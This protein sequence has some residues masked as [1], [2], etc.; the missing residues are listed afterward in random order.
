MNLFTQK[1]YE[2]KENLCDDL[3]FVMRR[4]FSIEDATDN[5]IFDFG[6]YL[7][8]EMLIEVGKYLKDLHPMPIWMKNWKKTC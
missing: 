1:Y 8:D 5:Q 6:L 4:N 7:L 2:F 3:A